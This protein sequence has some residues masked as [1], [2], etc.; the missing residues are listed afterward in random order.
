LR[1]GHDC[2]EGKGVKRKRVQERRKKVK[3]GWKCKKTRGRRG[4]KERDHRFYQKR[5]TNSSV[6]KE[7]KKKGAL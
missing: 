5:V 2:E 6:A 3:S 1:E 4:E 7:K